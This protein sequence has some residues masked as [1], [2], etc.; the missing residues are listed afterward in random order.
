MVCVILYLDNQ[1]ISQGNHGIN[2]LHNIITINNEYQDL[3]TWVLD[4]VKRQ[5]V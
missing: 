2:V 5:Q 4:M 1:D 3:V